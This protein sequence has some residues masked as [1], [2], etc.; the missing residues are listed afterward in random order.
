MLL[1]RTIG[2]W[3]GLRL[4]ER[5]GLL[6][7]RGRSGNREMARKLRGHG[8]R[9]L[10]LRRGV[11]RLGKRRV[12]W[13]GRR[14]VWRESLA[15]CGG[16][17]ACH[18][19]RHHR[20]RLLVW[21][22]IGALL[23][24]RILVQVLRLYRWRV[25]AILL[26]LLRHRRRILLMVVVH[27]G[28]LLPPR[29]SARAGWLYRRVIRRR[30]FP[31]RVS[32]RCYIGAREGTA[33]WGRLSASIFVLSRSKEQARSRVTPHG[34]GL[35]RRARQRGSWE[36]QRSRGQSLALFRAHNHLTHQ[37]LPQSTALRANLNCDNIT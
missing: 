23:L 24:L 34:L 14:R 7:R 6:L 11:C 8:I 1:G 16:N 12:I 25:L 36:P 33:G 9:R 22:G 30:F 4:V 37:A 10:R 32:W 26:L 13:R 29:G 3:V 21:R 18:V 15:L 27:G 31:V 17:A 5:R 19:R 20:R 35:G 28:Q 2:M